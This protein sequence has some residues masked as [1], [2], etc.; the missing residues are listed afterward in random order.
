MLT[1]V[2][3]TNFRLGKSWCTFQINIGINLLLNKFEKQ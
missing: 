2:I 1:G 3:P